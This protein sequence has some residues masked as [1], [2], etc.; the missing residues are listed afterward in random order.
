[1]RDTESSGVMADVSSW[2]WLHWTGLLLSICIAAINLYIGQIESQSTFF[3]IGVSFLLGGVLFL[4]RFWDPILYLLGVLHIG[5][6]GVI[7]V[8]G[9]MRFLAFG[10][11]TGILSAGLAAIALY[12]FA[13][14]MK[15][16]AR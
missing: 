16:N 7:W 2:N 14:E 5:A 3:V 12:L 8:L 9:G 1:M 15:S 11:V 4:T 13:E 6:L 10:I